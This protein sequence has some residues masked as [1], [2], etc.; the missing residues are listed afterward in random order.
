[1]KG[2]SMGNTCSVGQAIHEEPALLGAE[3][4]VRVPEVARPVWVCPQAVVRG[5][6]EEAERWDGLS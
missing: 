6:I 5:D 2:V 4:N 1:M 3:V